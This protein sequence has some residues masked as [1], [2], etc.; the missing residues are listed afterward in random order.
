MKMMGLRNSVFW[1]SWVVT[2]IVSFIIVC[3]VVILVCKGSLFKYSDG[4]LLFLYFFSF[5]LTLIALACLVTT[6]FS[7]AKTAGTLSPFVLLAAWLPYFAVSDAAQNENA[8]NLACLLSP[9]AFSLG[10][11]H[12][13][14]YESV[15]IGSQWNNAGEVIDNFRLSSAIALMF[16]DAAFYAAI[17]WYLE[18]VW[19]KEYGTH[20][21]WYFLFT[22][23]YW[24]KCFSCFASSQPR[25]RSIVELNEAPAMGSS[26][27]HASPSLQ[28]GSS[29][30]LNSASYAAP[31]LDDPS[32]EPDFGPDYESVPD[33][34]RANIGVKVRGLRKQFSR[35][36]NEVVAVHGLDLNLYTGQCF[37]L[38]GHNGAGSDQTQIHSATQCTPSACTIEVRFDVAA[39]SSSFSFFPAFCVALQ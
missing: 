14:S 38:L 21:K 2:Y 20:E 32:E 36:G 37:V 17:A 31:L 1:L 24:K 25:R 26:L 15:F 10:S 4:G 6:F 19:P 35:D 30:V 27:S 18:K 33:S 7:K 23:A 5:C 34:M 12:I 9:V 3:I 28:S 16:F 39:R 13:I 11:T 22:P 8:K 29:A